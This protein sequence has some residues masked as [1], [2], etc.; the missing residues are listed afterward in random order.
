[1]GTFGTVHLVAGNSQSSVNAW[2]LVLKVRFL[3]HPVVSNIFSTEET[4]ICPQLIFHLNEL[5]G[6]SSCWSVPS[7]RRNSALKIINLNLN[8]MKRD[9]G[10]ELNWA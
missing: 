2:I 3:G 6:E 5:I 1:M 9:G 7:I 8:A 10:R 4:F